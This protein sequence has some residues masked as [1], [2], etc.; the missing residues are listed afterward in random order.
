MPSLVDETAEA[1]VNEIQRF[2][3]ER[4]QD[5]TNIWVIEHRELKRLIANRC[6]WNDPD[7]HKKRVNEYRI[8]NRAV[9]NERRRELYRANAASL[10]ARS[11][12]RRRTDEEFAEKDRQRSR[13]YYARNGEIQRERMRAVRATNPDEARRKDR[14][15][16]AAN[17]DRINAARKLWREKKKEESK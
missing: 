8:A 13:D 11:A 14:E 2:R 1:V 6:Y 4:R 17:R 16:Y 12:E 3:D 5:L 10:A 9:I 7:R 15:R